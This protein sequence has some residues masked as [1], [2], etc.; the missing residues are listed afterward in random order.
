MK[1][2]KKNLIMIAVLFIMTLF[3]DNRVKADETDYFASDYTYKV[4]IYAGGQGTFANGSDMIEEEVR[5]GQIID[6]GQVLACIVMNPATDAAGNP[7]ENK[8]YAKGIRES[9]KDNNTVAGTVFQI[10]HDM[11]FV[12]AYA[13]K[14]GDIAYTVNYVLE[15]TGESLLPSETFYG[16]AGDKAVAAYRYI[17]GYV[18][19]AYNLAMVLKK[20]QDNRFTFYYKPGEN[21]GHYYYE[22]DGGVKY[23]YKDGETVVEHVPGR[24]I[25][26]DSP[27]MNSSTSVTNNQNSA[28]RVI[29]DDTPVNNTASENVNASEEIPSQQDESPKVLIDLD[30][31]EVALKNG[32]GW[33]ENFFT[34][35]EK[36]S[37]DEKSLS[38][39]IAA[40]V[41]VI[42]VI[43]AAVIVVVLFRHKKRKNCSEKE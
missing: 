2:I 40:C 37:S 36:E 20:D 5:P 43:A 7:V 38:G 33:L 16:N 3:P 41:G 8:Y 23:L 42:L 27:Q 12:V 24:I 34:D 4:R 17:D 1:R 19:Q 28:V 11:D 25:Y 35:F 29:E 26:I 39:L 14:G 32:G 15:S 30:E 9:G 10:T 31:E 22:T 21:A 6:V 18:P 13:M